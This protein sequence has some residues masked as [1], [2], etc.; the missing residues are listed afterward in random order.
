MDFGNSPCS[1]SM[2]ELIPIPKSRAQGQPPSPPF[3]GLFL[4]FSPIS[5]R[6]FPGF[7]PRTPVG[8]THLMDGRGGIP[9]PKEAEGNFFHAHGNPAETNPPRTQN[10]FLKGRNSILLPTRSFH[11]FPV[12]KPGDPPWVLLQDGTGALQRPE[13]LLVGILGIA[14]DGGVGAWPIFRLRKRGMG[15]PRLS[16]LSH[17]WSFHRLLE[18]L[19]RWSFQESS[20]SVENPW[21]YSWYSLRSVVHWKRILDHA[22]TPQN[23]FQFGI[24]LFVFHLQ[25]PKDLWDQDQL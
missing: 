19:D 18:A 5:E 4:H 25:A 9:I 16:L 14:A 11:R 20:K 10:S 8:S 24:C 22:K 1:H 23:S 7:N 6:L 12:G 17:L 21:G 13:F 15:I 3:S 2:V